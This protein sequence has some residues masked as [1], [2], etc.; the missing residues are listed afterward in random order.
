MH[1]SLAGGGSGIPRIAGLDGLG[2]ANAGDHRLRDTISA[3]RP[4]GIGGSF[5][6]IKDVRRGNDLGVNQR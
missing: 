5:G 4:A 3:P 2:C 1:E 6:Y